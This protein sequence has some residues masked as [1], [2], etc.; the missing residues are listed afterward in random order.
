MVKEEKKVRKIY[1][2]ETKIKAVQRVVAGENL[3][4]V[5]SGAV[6][7]LVIRSCLSSRLLIQISAL[8][9]LYHRI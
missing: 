5:A 8:N 4:D 7:R 1:S 6:K 9:R 2:Y 3:K